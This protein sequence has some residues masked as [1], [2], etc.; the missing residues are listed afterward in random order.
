LINSRSGILAPPTAIRILPDNNKRETDVSDGQVFPV[1]EAWAKR[2]H[3]DAAAYDAACARVDSD[4]EG[5]WR[6]VAGRL[7]WMT[8][9]PDQGRLLRQG[10]LP[11]PLVRRRGAERLGTTASTA[12]GRPAA[13]RPP[14]SGKGDEPTHSGGLTYRE[15]TPKSAAWP[16]CSRAWAW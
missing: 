6:D 16:M 8:A 4:P 12:P 14:S 3:M 13:T 2:A 15:A 5:F 7:D 1:P 11:H 10:R 9:P